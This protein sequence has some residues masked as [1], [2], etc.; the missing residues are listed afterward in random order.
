MSGATPNASALKSWVEKGGILITCKSA[1][2]WASSNGLAHLNIKSKK[3]SKNTQRKS[4]LNAANETGAQFVGGAIFETQLDLGHPIAYGYSNNKLPIFKRSVMAVEHTKNPYA[5]PVVYNNMPLLSGYI[6]TPNQKYM[7]NSSAIV[8][9][10]VGRGKTISFVDNPNF[11]GFWLGTNKLFA[12]AVFFGQ[13][14][15]RRTVST[16]K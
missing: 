7:S 15:D 4:Y 11:R 2:R 5:N 3:S 10:G 1:T 12:N 14:I 9:S 13:I 16:S 6:S 8:V